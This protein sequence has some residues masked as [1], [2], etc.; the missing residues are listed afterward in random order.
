M[1]RITDLITFNGIASQIKDQI[2]EKMV[3]MGYLLP[4]QRVSD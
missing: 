4:W 1:I 2:R 3:A